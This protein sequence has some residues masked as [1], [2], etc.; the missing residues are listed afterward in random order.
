M[1]QV[2]VLGLRETGLRGAGGRIQS[3]SPAPLPLR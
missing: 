1:K 3:P 2:Q